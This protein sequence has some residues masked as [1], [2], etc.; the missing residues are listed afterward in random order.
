MIAVCP[1]EVVDFCRAFL[2]FVAVYLG[3]RYGRGC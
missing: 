3:T 2:F 1:L